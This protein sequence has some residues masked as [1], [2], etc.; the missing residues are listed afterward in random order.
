[1]PVVIEDVV[2]VSAVPVESVPHFQVCAFALLSMV[3]LPVAAEMPLSGT[4]VA[5]LLG[6]AHAPSPRQNVD[7]LAPVPLFRL[8]AGKLPVTS[9]LRSTAP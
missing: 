5:T 3:L 4:L 7:E 1:V 6:V 8:F 2:N 9:A